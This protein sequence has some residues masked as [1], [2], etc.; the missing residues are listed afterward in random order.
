MV[1]KFVMPTALLLGVLCSNPLAQTVHPKGVTIWD[2]AKARTGVTFI[3]APDGTAR[4]VGMLGDLIN[5]WRAPAPDDALL[6]KVPILNSPG[7]ILAVHGPISVP[8]YP[9]ARFN[10]D[11]IRLQRKQGLG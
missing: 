6:V 3:T 7:H 4:L 5:T 11:R 2:W 9:R 8:G 1:R 10:R